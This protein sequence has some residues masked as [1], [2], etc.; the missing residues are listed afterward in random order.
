[1]LGTCCH[2]RIQGDREG[3]CDEYDSTDIEF[4]VDKESVKEWT[5]RV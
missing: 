4:N 3:R 2:M 1:M 5:A